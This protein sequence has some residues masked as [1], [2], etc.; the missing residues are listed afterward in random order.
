MVYLLEP[1]AVW[2]VVALP[3]VATEIALGHSFDGSAEVV[4]EILVDNAILARSNDALYIH[5]ATLEALSHRKM[6]HPHSIPSLSDS[7]VTDTS[8]LPTDATT[9]HPGRRDPRLYQEQHRH[10]FQ[11]AVPLLEVPE[12]QLE[13]AGG[14]QFVSIPA[15]WLE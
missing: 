12:S 15:P 11:A 2:L 5:P 13:E 3:E 9:N 8:V 4:D 10:L 1:V 6:E 14:Y 7:P